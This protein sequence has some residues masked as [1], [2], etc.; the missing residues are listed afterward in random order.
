M[1][2]KLE[3]VPIEEVLIEV[4]A[5][6]LRAALISKGRLVDLMIEPRR[7]EGASSSVY[8]GRVVRSAPGLGAAFID[9]G[10][11]RPALLDAGRARLAEGAVLVE[12]VEEAA[13]D[14]GARVSRRMA[15]A[16]RYVVLLPEGAGIAHSRRIAD[17]EARRRLALLAKGLARPGTGLIV[18]QAAVAAPEAVAAEVARLSEAWRLVAARAKDATPPLCLHDDGDGL[19]R[20]L[21]ELPAQRGR[22]VFDDRATAHRA[23]QLAEHVYPDLAPR[24]ELG[25]PGEKLFERYGVAEILAGLDAPRVALPAGGEIAIEATTAL[26]AI[27]VDSGQGAGA[28]ARLDANLEAAAEIGR[29]VRLRDLAGLIV[30]DFIR[31]EGKADRAQVLAALGRAV[32]GDRRPVQ[33][34]GWT[35]AGLVELIRPR[36][37]TPDMIE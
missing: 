23:R 13:G 2:G 30:V 15:L 24:I 28:G 9:I 3:D 33:V 6:R 18:R 19:S 25:P 34:L 7:R 20:L 32:A 22:I 4:G 36:A 1:A 14:K 5:E 37:R 27:D 16:G 10:L 26:T 11:A 35:A 17:Q 29:Q 21:R 31:L 8:I 12:I